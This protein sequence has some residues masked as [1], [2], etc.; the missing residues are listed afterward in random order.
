MPT[1]IG[2]TGDVM[3]GRQVDARHQQADRAPEAVWG[4]VRERM[5]DLDAVC[6]N[7]ECALSTRGEK[8]TRTKRPFHFRA[9]PEWAVAALRRGNVAYASLAN[10]HLLD[11]REPALRD[12]LAEL[13]DAGVAHAGAGEDREA[14]FAPAVFE[15]DDCRLAVVSLTDNTPEY[16]AGPDAPGVARAEMD[17]SDWDR[18]EAALDRAR[19]GDPDLL[20]ASLHSGPNMVERPARKHREFARRLVDAGVDLVHG[21]SAH[22]FQGIGL[23]EGVPVVHDCG[24]FVDD[25]VVDDD[26]RND[27]SFL[28]EATIEGSRIAEL[29]LRPVAIYDRAVHLAD[30]RSAAWCRERMRERSEPFG[31]A[32]AF[33]RRGDGL[34]LPVA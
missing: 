9:D 2:F 12:T 30:D 10:N 14:A 33:E 34:R 17:G 8:W 5:T 26:L 31:T 1:T 16:A 29:R 21:H 19:D 32:D 20:V 11:F 27:L 3:L 7:L 24:D 25:Y 15:V 28:F 4:N 13:D 23:R 22:V 6:I 18:V